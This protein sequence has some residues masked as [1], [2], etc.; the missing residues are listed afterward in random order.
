MIFLYLKKS[1]LTRQ[2]LMTI[3]S[4]FNLAFTKFQD[5]RRQ[6]IEAGMKNT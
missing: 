5:L 1:L 6:Q 3:R 4:R 2:V